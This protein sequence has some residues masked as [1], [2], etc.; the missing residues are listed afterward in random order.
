MT[1]CEVCDILGC[2]SVA[3]WVVVSNGVSSA[4]CDSCAAE[5]VAVGVTIAPYETIVTTT[6]QPIDGQSPSENDL[7]RAWERCAIPGC[8]RAWHVGVTYPNTRHVHLCPMHAARAVIAEVKKKHEQ[9]AAP[10]N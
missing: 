8:N 7:D 5:F 3:R 4:F 9:A 2:R 1:T 10:L 6:I